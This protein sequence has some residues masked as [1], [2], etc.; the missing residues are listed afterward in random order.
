MPSARFVLYE[1]PACSE[2]FSF[3]GFCDFC[4]ARLDRVVA[5]PTEH[6]ERRAAESNGASATE[7][8]TRL[9]NEALPHRR[10]LPLPPR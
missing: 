3:A 4:G 2:A 7:F 5:I 10:P 8:A 1:C 9:L 6:I